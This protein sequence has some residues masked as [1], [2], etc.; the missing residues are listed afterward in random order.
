[1]QSEKARRRARRLKNVLDSKG[2]QLP[3]DVGDLIGYGMRKA[4]RKHKVKALEATT[5]AI[6][7]AGATVLLVGAI[8]AGANA[9]NPVGWGIGAVVVLAGTGLLIYKLVRR[10]TSEKRAKK[11]GFSRG[12]YPKMLVRRF[13]KA[14][15]EGPNSIVTE[16]L[17]AVLEAYGVDALSLV[18]GG[19]DQVDLACARIAR[20]L[21]S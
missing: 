14:F 10:G 1:V 9:W 7:A 11:R 5:A 16:S 18:M 13:L 2:G 19:A 12:D 21:K 17:A 20:H 15:S 3:Q 8:I 6:G 4:T